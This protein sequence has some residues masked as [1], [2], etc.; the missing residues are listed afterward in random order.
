MTITDKS[1][2]FLSAD[3]IPRICVRLTAVAFQAAVQGATR[4]ARA[5][6][7]RPIRA[8]GLAGS[9]PAGGGFPLE[10]SEARAALSGS[11]GPG[12]PG[13]TKARDQGIVAPCGPGAASGAR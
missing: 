3:N 8:A 10:S 6:R 2:L 5:N 12:A 4:G 7:Q 1:P 9:S 13:K 11:G